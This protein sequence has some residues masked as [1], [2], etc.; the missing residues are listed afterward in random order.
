M[1]AAPRNVGVNRG[2]PPHGRIFLLAVPLAF[3][4]LLLE[5]RTARAFVLLQGTAFRTTA[6]SGHAASEARTILRRHCGSTSGST[7]EM[8]G[9]AAAGRGW[10]GPV[11]WSGR[12]STSA[13]SCSSRRSSSISSSSSGSGSRRTSS[14]TD[15]RARVTALSMGDENEENRSV[16]EEWPFH[17]SRYV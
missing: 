6:T 10:G 8:A 5:V 14:S 17:K 16:E 4:V 1:P 13:G 12:G 15:S 7:L 3:L 11:G 9:D 2:N